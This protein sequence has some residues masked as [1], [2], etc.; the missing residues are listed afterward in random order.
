M[1]SKIG[2]YA[3]ATALALTLTLSSLVGCG[4]GSFSSADS[5]AGVTPEVTPEATGGQSSVVGTRSEATGGQSSVVGTQSEATGGQ[6][7]VD[8]NPS[9]SKVYDATYLTSSYI[10]GNN[11]GPTSLGLCDTGWIRSG[12]ACVVGQPPVGNALQS[13][14]T[15][16]LP[17]SETSLSDCIANSQNSPRTYIWR[18]IESS[19]TSPVSSTMGGS[20]AIASTGGSSS[21][22]ATGGSVAKTATGGSSAVM[23]TGGSSAVMATG[24]SSTAGTATY[25]VTYLNQVASESVQAPGTCPTGQSVTACTCVISGMQS[26][27]TSCNPTACAIENS[28]QY[29]ESTF[30][31]TCV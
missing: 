2:F 23:A 8:S 11:E 10:G 26:S 6:T 30:T 21:F 9:N 3:K 19:T 4:G 14:N 27:L 25:S 22:A 5:D 28:K 29:P 12:S 17:N 24:G 1:L 15:F 18:C 7:S 20:S 16:D 13:F 31:W